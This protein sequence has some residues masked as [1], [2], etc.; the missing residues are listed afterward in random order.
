M[1][2]KR[3]V[4]I[5]LLK[6]CHIQTIL[7]LVSCYQKILALFFCK[8]DYNSNKNTPKFMPG[9]DIRLGNSAPDSVLVQSSVVNVSGRISKKIKSERALLKYTITI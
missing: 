8:H 4:R 9:T 7:M 1:F 5:T 2:C 3:L 6:P